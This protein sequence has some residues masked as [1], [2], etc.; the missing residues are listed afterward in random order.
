MDKWII[1]ILIVALGIVFY[2]N[3]RKVEGYQKMSPQEAKVQLEEDK[4][5]VLLDVRTREEYQE[6]HIEGSTLIP[7]NV[8]ETEVRTKIPNKEEK[9]I[10]Y[11]RSGNRSKTAANLLLSMGYKHV[12]D[13]G[14]INS[15]P[16]EI[17]MPTSKR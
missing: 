1:A 9:I 11:C 10:I 7:L 5:I 2:N 13:L 8:L 16:Y 15:W 4:D 12:Y 6:K 14:G 17:I 3:N